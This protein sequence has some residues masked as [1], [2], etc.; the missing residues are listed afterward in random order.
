MLEGIIK[1]SLALFAQKAFAD[2]SDTTDGFLDVSY[3]LDG[4]DWQDVGQVT[5]TDW[6]NFSVTI[7]VSSWDDIN[8]LQI[9]LEPALSAD[10][11]TIYL[12]G[13]WLEVDYGQ[14]LVGI[15]QDG[16][17][18]ALS[19]IGA[20]GDAV[21]NALN[22]VL[23]PSTTPVQPQNLSNQS[24]APIVPPPPT[25]RHTFQVKNL[26]SFNARS[27]Q[28]L[29]PGSVKSYDDSLPASGTAEPTVTLQDKNT[30]HITGTCPSYYYTILLFRNQTDYETDPA[31]AV[32]NEAIPCTNGNFDQTFSDTD[33]P[34]NLA[35]GTYYLMVASQGQTGTWIPYQIFYPIL[36]DNASSS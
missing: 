28:W 18:A 3:S 25:H 35:P 14:S 17:N 5:A 13:M 21:N 15:L 6:Q 7:P 10:T 11:P 19:A 30:I 23:P 1:D 36:I 31:A 22:S 8:K 9:K 26:V 12:D 16:A 20:L 29:P 33:F 34:A 2:A 24:Q 32:F 27:P 4:T